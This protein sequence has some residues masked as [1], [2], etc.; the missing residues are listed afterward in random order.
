MSRLIVSRSTWRIT[1]ALVL[2]VPIAF[3]STG[4]GTAMGAEQTTPATEVR[5][6][7]PGTIPVGKELD[8]RLQSS[9]SSATAKA[10]QRFEATTLVDIT[11]SG[12][13][14]IPAGSVVQG[15]VSEATPAGRVNRTGSM[16]LAFN[17]ITIAGHSHSIRAM[18][19]QVFKSGGIREE[20]GTAGAGAGVGGVIG[21][22]LGGVQGALVGAAIGAGGAIA[23]TEGKDIELPAGSV[24]RIR[25]DS[26]LALAS[27]Q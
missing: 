23:S 25:F 19:T 11:Q 15:V 26:P 2:V 22:I 20:K 13:I 18:A 16:T 10:E 8:V 5:S 6:D 4:S 9:L 21:G 14:L 17:R 24:I 1:I 27:A 7:Q 3:G 12:R